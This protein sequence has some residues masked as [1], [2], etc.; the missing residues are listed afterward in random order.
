MLEKNTGESQCE[1]IH[2]GRKSAFDID[3]LN[4]LVPVFNKITVSYNE[5]VNDL[6]A[7]LEAMPNEEVSKTTEI[8]SQ[9][10]VKIQEWHVKVKK[11]GGV[12]KG[13]WTID[14]DCGDGY[15]CWKYPESEILYWHSYED[16]F[17]GRVLISERDKMRESQTVIKKQE[18][19]II[20]YEN[21]FSPD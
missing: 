20:L 2:I 4:Q 6:I 7:M 1:V 13:L 15:Y 8:E 16:G 3:E 9:I 19:E 21:S 12:P 10:N 11:L 18:A 14:F 5:E 17:S